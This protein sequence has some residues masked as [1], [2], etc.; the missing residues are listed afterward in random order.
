MKSLP[1]FSFLS[2]LGFCL[3]ASAEM[4][5]VTKTFDPSVIGYRKDN[6]VISYQD[7]DLEITVKQPIIQDFGKSDKAINLYNKIV[8][9]ESKQIF[10]H[11]NLTTVG[12]DYRYFV[13]TGV[14]LTFKNKSASPIYID[15]NSSA[16]SIGSY[17]GKPLLENIRFAEGAPANLPPLLIMPNQTLTKNF[18]R[19]DYV[20]K[21]KGGSIFYNNSLGWLIDK[22]DLLFEKNVFGDGNFLFMSGVNEKKMI[23]FQLY[24]EPEYNTLTPYV[25]LKKQESVDKFIAKVEA[26]K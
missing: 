8:D 7:A 25:D 5:P 17:Y 15:L 4:L 10:R 3:S 9:K 22:E 20:Y 19:N 18:Y 11:D 12:V 1:L 16:I 6:A 2:I 26:K 13:C 24:L 23:P 14:A 21:T